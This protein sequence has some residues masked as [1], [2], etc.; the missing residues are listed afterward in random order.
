MGITKNGIQ[1][2]DVSVP[3]RIECGCFFR[4]IL[5]GISTVEDTMISLMNQRFARMLITTWNLDFNILKPPWIGCW[6]NEHDFNVAVNKETSWIL[7]EQARVFLPN[8]LGLTNIFW[9]A[10]WWMVGFQVSVLHVLIEVAWI[11]LCC[12]PEIVP[13]CCWDCCAFGIKWYI[14]H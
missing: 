6:C 14:Q 7:T 13:A 11:E 4:I 5:T 1:P 3:W 2:P 8:D 12:L 10:D 9:K